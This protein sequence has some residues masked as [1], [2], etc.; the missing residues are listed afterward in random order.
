MIKTWTA[1]SNSKYQ[2]VDGWTRLKCAIVSP[3][4]SP[5]SANQCILEEIQ[6]IKESSAKTSAAAVHQCLLAVDTCYVNGHTQ[7]ADG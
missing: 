3:G 1:G 7:N 6:S 2:Q 5:G 4:T